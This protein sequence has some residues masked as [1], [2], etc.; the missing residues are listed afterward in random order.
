MIG[1]DKLIMK[2]AEAARVHACEK[3]IRRYEE[4]FLNLEKLPPC[5]VFY[6][7]HSFWLADG[8]HRV[9]AARRAQFE[10]IEC[11]VSDGGEREA[12]LFALSANHAH[13]LVSNAQDRKKIAMILLNDPEWSQ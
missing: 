10:A 9:E 5:R 7:G 1:L 13:G 12:I 6:D 3:T 11:T 8:R 2:S 4:K